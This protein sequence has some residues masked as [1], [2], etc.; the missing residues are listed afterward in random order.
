MVELVGKGGDFV[1][2]PQQG[3]FV[4]GKA[5]S[6]GNVRESGVVHVLETSPLSTMPLISAQVFI[7]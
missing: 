4:A 2:G 5:H 3:V 1:T 7:A 6:Q